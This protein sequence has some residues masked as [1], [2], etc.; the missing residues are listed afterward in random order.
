M[1][2]IITLLLS[3]YT[4]FAFAQT[5]DS[6]FNISDYP[7][8]DISAVSN[9]TYKSISVKISNFSSEDVKI[10]FPEGGIFINKSDLEQNLIVL[11]YD[12]LTLDANTSSEILIGTACANPKR[13]VPSNGRTNWTYSYDK[14]V[15][16]LISFYHNN[17]PM[18][19][20]LTGSEYHDTQPKRHNF[21]QMGVWVYYEADKEQ[22]LNFATKYIFDNNKE[23]AK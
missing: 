7:D 1:K 17:R 15:G 3:F 22:I 5:Q 18:V 14:K 6:F 8:I 23:E 21:L 9:G 13:K 19:E 12:Y 10:T 11:F 2:K 4:V 16:D 20:L